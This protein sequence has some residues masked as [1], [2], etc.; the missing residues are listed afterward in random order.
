MAT[1]IPAPDLAAVKARQQAT[2]ASGDYSAVATRIQVVAE[3]LCD[4]ADL[5]PGDRVLDVATGSGNAAIAAARMG[6]D[7]TG[8]DYVPR[9]LARGRERA[10]AERLPVRF[11][12]GDAEDMPVPDGAFDAVT[13]VFGVMFA[14]DHQ[15]AAAEML[16]VCRPGGTIALAAWTPDGFIGGLLRALTRYV[17]PPAGLRSPLL[18]GTGDHV[19]SLLGGEVT[20]V[21]L[22]ERTFTWRFASPGDFV[23]F[24][25][26]N[27]GPTLKVFEAVPERA[28]PDL[29]SDLHE[30][31]AA[32][33]RRRD[34]RTLAIPSTYLELT[35]R[36]HQGPRTGHGQ[37][38][39]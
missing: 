26:T 7:V 25:A 10:A 12:D 29:V 38:A 33:D 9:L 4:A 30:L 39:S 15:R 11:R 8:I 22:R 23:S 2:W 16:R 24:F 31:A 37:G 34:G 35:A 3:L 6:C 20:E 21:A 18:W 19:R 14:P 32:G 36:R 13:S 5:R 28:R 1:T 17:P 27:Y